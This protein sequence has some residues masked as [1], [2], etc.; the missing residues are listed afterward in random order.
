M[1]VKHSLNRAFQSVPVALILLM[2]ITPVSA[3]K[4][5]E[6]HQPTVDA[7]IQDLSETR[8]IEDHVRSF[9]VSGDD[10]HLEQAWRLLEPMLEVESVEIN[11]LIDAATVAQARHEFEP[12]L[13]LINRAL[14][15]SPHL[16]RAWLL[17]A[18]IHLVRGEVDAAEKA[19]I[20]LRQVT[21]LVAI[22]CRARVSIAAGQAARVFPKL[23]AVIERSVESDREV[24]AWASSVAGDAASALD[25]AQS[26]HFYRRSLHLAESAQVR[27]AL[28]DVLIRLERFSEAKSALSQGSRALPLEL[29]R[30]IVV[31]RMGHRHEIEHEIREADR[32]FR[33][34]LAAGDW[35]HA[36][37]MARFYL[38]VI[39]RP[40]LARHLA[41]INWQIQR[42]PEDLLLACRTFIEPVCD[43]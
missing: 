8:N 26:V 11:T 5:E 31:S 14:A 23:R 17:K 39:E 16:D 1:I 18:S 37:E 35:L 38:D 36:R 2:M 42:E 19:C 24:L 32:Q 28:V 9:R 34:W 15:Q 10:Q 33:Q 29:R 41:G 13:V 25:L 27:A 40:D 22:T 43:E 12:A 7:I 30:W 4:I 3:H 6:I 21:I 20:R